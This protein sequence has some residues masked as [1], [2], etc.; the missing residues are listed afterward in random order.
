VKRLYFRP[1]QVSRLAL[2]VIAL[3]AF[4]VLIAVEAFPLQMR[5]PHID[6]KIAAARL[7]R[8]A[9]AAIKAEKVRRGIRIDPEVD[10]GNSGLIGAPVTPVTSNTGDLRAK[11]ISVNPNFAAAVV[12]MLK[13][14]SIERGDVVAVGL[15]GS[16]PALNIA[17][18]AALETLGAKP[19]AISSVAAS[20]WGANLVELLWIDMEKLLEQKHLFGFRSIA[21]SR[22]GIDDH[23][24][25]MSQEGREMLD[26]AI[27]RNGLIRIDSQSLADAIERRMKIYDEHAA[28]RP[29]KLYVNV[30]GGSASVGTHVGKKQLVPGLNTEL[31]RGAPVDSVMLRFLERKVPVIHLS[32]VARLARQY[33]LASSQ[34]GLPSVGEG[35]VYVRAEYNRWLAIAGLVV[36]L[37]VM[38]GARV[39]RTM[40]TPT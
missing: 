30:G 3:I 32:S 5:Q 11:W 19:I 21:A 28:Q 40:A 20:E 34:G 33:G 2:V 23:G 31:P 18:F 4:A 6:E 22:G 27:L 35:T 26:H 37:G 24:F 36:L 9:M 29:I 25:G 17:T 7:A 14:A 12:D 10:P 8:D 15:S 13:R 39:T 1:Q 16:F 38:L